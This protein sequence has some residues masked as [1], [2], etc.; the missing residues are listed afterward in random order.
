MPTSLEKKFFMPNLQLATS[1]I[2]KV[3]IK[4]GENFKGGFQL[5][6]RVVVNDN[7][8]F[9]SAE[10][11]EAIKQLYRSG[12]NSESEYELLSCYFD[13]INQ[14]MSREVR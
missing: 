3:E 6:P 1:E 5:L 8:A 12:F 2:K 9:S 4:E 10:G 7:Y 11:V 13:L 14:N